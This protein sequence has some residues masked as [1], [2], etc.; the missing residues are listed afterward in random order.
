MILFLTLH[1]TQ[2]RGRG[3][4]LLQYWT[5]LVALG[6]KSASQGCV[7]VTSARADCVCQETIFTIRLVPAG[8]HF[9]K[10]AYWWEL[11]LSVVSLHF[12]LRPRPF[13]E[14]WSHFTNSWVPWLA[15]HLEKKIFFLLIN[16]SQL[17][18]KPIP[19]GVR[20][21]GRQRASID[22]QDSLILTEGGHC[23]G[24]GDNNGQ[25]GYPQCLLP[26]V[27]GFVRFQP[28]AAF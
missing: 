7:F 24:Q 20:G 15:N 13:A 5:H 3:K 6:S 8:I 17:K 22:W 19:T 21:K 12:S 26:I 10:P 9:H 14:E 4:S 1:S 2:S 25:P 23:Q 18:A 27:L 11:K 28:G 16:N